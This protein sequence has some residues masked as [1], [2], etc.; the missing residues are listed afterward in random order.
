MNI[1]VLGAFAAALLIGCGSDDTAVSSQEDGGGIQPADGLPV[2][3]ATDDAASGADTSAVADTGT[4]A[5]TGVGPSDTGISASD[6]GAKTDGSTPAGAMKCGAVTCDAK[7]QDCC[8]IGGTGSCVTKG[9]ACGG[10]RFACTSVDDCG[11]GQVCCA[12]GAG[13]GGA[14]CTAAGSCPTST[15]CK[16]NADCTGKLKTCVDI[17]IVK[18]C[19]T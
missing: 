8:S 18:I 3:T 12:S 2:D 17:G 10:V 7:T 16:S 13:T 9:G 11:S 19:S 1:H 15:T 4:V 6:T 14:S 5:D